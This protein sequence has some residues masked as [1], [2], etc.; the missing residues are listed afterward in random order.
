MKVCVLLV[1]V[2]LSIA[3]PSYAKNA[4][5]YVFVA[6]EGRI[7]GFLDGAAP[8]PLTD[9]AGDLRDAITR[10]EYNG[11]TVTA[12]RLDARILVQVMSREEV[13]GEFRVHAHIT[14]DGREADLI[15]TSTHQWKQAARQIVDQLS[16]WAKAHSNPSPHQ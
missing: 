16:A 13:E 2:L 12:K 4:K 14:I 11:L 5:V 15:G 1:A 10:G 6:P 7:D 3:A 9:S 8:A